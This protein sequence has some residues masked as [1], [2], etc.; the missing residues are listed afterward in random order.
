[1]EISC[2]A[3]YNLYNNNQQWYPIATDKF[4]VGTKGSYKIYVAG[5]LLFWWIISYETDIKKFKTEY[6]PS[7]FS[8]I[9]EN[10]RYVQIPYD[11]RSWRGFL[12]VSFETQEDRDNAMQ[13]AITA[14]D[15][16]GNVTMDA[17]GTKT[18][19]LSNNGG[20]ISY[21]SQDSAFIKI[22]NVMVAFFEPSA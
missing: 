11:K 17:E 20:G 9:T 4:I 7:G 18:I 14:S 10:E 12:S 1:M 6:N 21:S 22:G 13:L 2:S 19:Y 15:S 16:L 5:K 3:P 8:K